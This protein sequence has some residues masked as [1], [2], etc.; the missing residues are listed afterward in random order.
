MLA[1]ERTASFDLNWLS[2]RV[3]S[4]T[5]EGESRI[6]DSYAASDQRRVS[7][8]CPHC[9]HRHFP[10]FFKHVDWQKRHDE[11]GEV[12]EHLPRTARMHCEACGVAWQE[13]ERLQALQT[14]RWHQT[15]PFNCCGSNQAPLEAYERAWR[16]LEAE[17]AVVIG[18]EPPPA[19]ELRCATRCSKVWDWWEDLAEGRY[20]VYR[21]S[22]LDLQVVAGGQP[23]RRLSGWEAV[24]AVAEGPAIRHRRE[25][26]QREGQCGS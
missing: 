17:D 6:A 9:G 13:G 12:I 26:A 3:C 21:A 11:K 22:V 2:L 19:A 20:A 25:V 5:I 1:E 14:C 23:A 7:I 4:P 10:D 16:A 15:R 18:E 24:L 8:A